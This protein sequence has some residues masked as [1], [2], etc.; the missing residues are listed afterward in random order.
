MNKPNKEFKK[1]KQVSQ[2][3]AKFTKLVY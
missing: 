2:L 1:Q 3:A